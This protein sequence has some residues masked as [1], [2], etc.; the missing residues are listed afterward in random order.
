[1]MSVSTPF[2]LHPHIQSISKACWLFLDK[3]SLPKAVNS[4][5]HFLHSC[6]GPGHHRHLTPVSALA[7]PLLS[8]LA[9]CPVLPQNPDV[10]LYHTPDQ[11]PPSPSDYQENVLQGPNSHMR[12]ILFCTLP[13]PLPHP[14][15]PIPLPYGLWLFLIWIP[16][17]SSTN[18][19][20]SC[21]RAFTVFSA[22]ECFP[23]EIY[24][25]LP[26]IL[27]ICSQ[28]PCLS[29]TNPD[30]SSHLPCSP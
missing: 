6:P 24:G 17:C 26:Q 3:I 21:R 2:L 12:A 29:E 15:H 23:S 16:G 30:Q 28:R 18:W 20:W 4:S 27:Y 7:F 19:A 14:S 25:S 9:C 8:F 11:N 1:M 13:L 22:Q 5:H 10:R